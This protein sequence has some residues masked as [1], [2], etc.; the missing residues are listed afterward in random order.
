MAEVRFLRSGLNDVF[1]VT[2][3]Q[4]RFILRVYRAGRRTDDDIL[5]ECALLAHL[6]RAGVP[7]TA[8][9]PTDDGQQFV[10]GHAPEGRRQLLLDY[11]E[12]S[13]VRSGRA[14]GGKPSVVEVVEQYATVAAAVHTAADGFAVPHLRL[15][16]DVEHLIREPAR[17]A[18]QL[19]VGRSDVRRV[20]DTTADRLGELVEE[21]MPL[22]DWGPCH[23]DLSGGNAVLRDGQLTLFDFD[24]GGP[25]PR[26]Y[27]LAVF[28]WSMGLHGADSTVVDRYHAAYRA[29]R[30]L[31]EL[32]R[33]QDQLFQAVRQLWFIGMQT[34]NSGDWG[35]L[36]A[37]DDFVDQEFALLANLAQRI[38]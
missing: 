6:R 34:A 10:V 26:A 17:A 24:C 21:V 19:V 33:G 38:D 29:A 12:G 8:A 9:V 37:D 11:A 28:G 32:D 20:L 1:E 18:R 16:L 2:A 36:K 23:G 31:P 7:V 5:W 22:L 30:Y 3:A 25:G 14:K 15:V 4:G 35:Y 13:L 27:D